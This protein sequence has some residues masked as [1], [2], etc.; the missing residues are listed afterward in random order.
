[1][2]SLG[3]YYLKKTKRKNLINQ[4][5]L[6]TSEEMLNAQWRNVSDDNTP[7]DIYCHGDP[8]NFNDIVI[9]TCTLRSESSDLGITMS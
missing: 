9:R 5:M 3:E 8:P 2:D 1:M 7:A 4:P 6:S